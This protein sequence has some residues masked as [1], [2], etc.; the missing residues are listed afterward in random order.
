MRVFSGNWRGQWSSGIDFGS[1]RIAGRFPALGVA[2]PRLVQ[3][4]V[5]C[6]AL[7]IKDKPPAVAREA[8]VTV[9][10]RCSGRATKLVGWTTLDRTPSETGRLS[11]PSAW[12]SRESSPLRVSG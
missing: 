9:R 7:K 10:V 4:E 3:S 12:L 1:A 8:A 5:P 2:H 6:H 11:V